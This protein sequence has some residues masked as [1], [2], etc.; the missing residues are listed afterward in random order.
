MLVSDARRAR[1][2]LLDLAAEA[3]A[4]GVD[5]IYLRDL[6]PSPEKRAS[7]VRDLRQRTG[8]AAALLINGDAEM[9]LA[10]GTGLHLRERDPAL[11]S[12]R[13]TLGPAALIGR[14]VHAAGG[15]AAAVGADYVLAGHVYPSASKPGRP[16]LGVDGLAAIAAAAPCPV[17]AIG[18]I[19]PER[20]AAVVRAGAAGVAVI[21]AIAE[22]DDPRA[23]A[24]ELRAALD[25][26]LHEES[27]M[28]QEIT[29]TSTRMEV[30]V[31]GKAH[32]LDEGATIHDFLASKGMTDAMAIVERNGEIV[33]RAVYAT[34]A[35]CDGD[36]LEVV[37]AVGGG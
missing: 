1:L 26:A 36:R 11:A 20:V 24:A 13:A 37:H 25:R 21:G 9:A 15:A 35:L 29:V 10:L 4:G 31:N 17:I 16:P 6:D 18:G 30:V 32:A 8:E 28:R 3:V 19:T 14:A 5:A 7:A 33:P 23:A 22:A 27:A 12:A 2:S 34:T